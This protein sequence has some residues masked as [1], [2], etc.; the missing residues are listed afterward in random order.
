MDCFFLTAF[1][2]S[3]IKN[4]LHEILENS[5]LVQLVDNIYLPIK[6]VYKVAIYLEYIL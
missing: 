2:L 1:V 6:L 4:E 3:Y 5:C